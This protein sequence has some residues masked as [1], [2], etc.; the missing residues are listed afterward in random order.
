MYLLD[1]NIFLE[2]LLDQDHAQ[3]CQ[4]LIASLNLEEPAW[5]TSF[6]LHAIEAILSQ[7]KRYKALQSFL[8]FLSDHPFLETYSTTL[9]EEKKICLLAPK[10]NLD[11]DDTLQYFVAKKRGLILV[12]LDKDFRKVSDVVVRSPEE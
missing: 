12:T 7:K 6:S 10:V 5:V 4:K 1:T 11:F 9:I 3:A 2:I 8:S